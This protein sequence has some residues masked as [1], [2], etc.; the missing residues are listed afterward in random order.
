M[1]FSEV[2]GPTLAGPV[3]TNANRG[4]LGDSLRLYTV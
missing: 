3:F 2:V 1:R 4:T